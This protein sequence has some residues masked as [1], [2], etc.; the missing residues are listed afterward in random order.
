MAGAITVG[1]LTTVVVFFPMVFMRGIAGVMFKQL[2]FVVGFA[3][4]CG[5]FVA[6]TLV[7]ML[8]G[9][10]LSA[11]RFEGGKPGSFSHKLVSTILG[12][13]HRME[14]SYK[15]LLHFTLNHRLQVLGVVVA[16][17]LGSIGLVRLVGNEFMPATDEGEVRVS[18]EM[19]VGTKL[20]LM[21]EKFRELADIIRKEVPEMQSLEESIGGGGWRGGSHTGNFTVRLSR[22]GER[23]R[24]SE[25]IAT[26][27]RKSSPTCPGSSS[28]RALQAAR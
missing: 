6:L 8:C 20:S 16:I 10:Y 13:F 17:L 24:S 3:N 22:R 14:N 26:D 5:L 7:P 15:R 23:D 1:A 21:D 18:V 19:E 2:A 28:G 12:F 25:E 27:L 11:E 9:R 4:L